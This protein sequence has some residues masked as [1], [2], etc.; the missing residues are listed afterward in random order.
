MTLPFFFF[1]YEIEASLLLSVKMGDV[2]ANHF[3]PYN[4][5]LKKNLSCKCFSV[6]P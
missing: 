2:R 4:M 3:V 1:F 6:M 5:C